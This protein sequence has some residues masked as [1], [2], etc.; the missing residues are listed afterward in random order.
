[1]DS[2]PLKELALECGAHVCGIAD[3]DL[4]QELPTIPENLLDGYTRAVSIGMAVPYGAFLT[5]DRAPTRLYMHHYRT[6][7]DILDRIALKI[8]AA[9]ESMGGKALAI[10]AS[11]ILDHKQLLGNIS[12]KAVA[13]VAG[14]GWQGKNLLLINPQ[15]GSRLRLVTVLTDLNLDPDAPVKNRCGKCSKCADAC[16][17][18]AIKN[19]TF[20]D[21]PRSRDEALYFERCVN[22]LT[23]DFAEELGLGKPV[24]GVCIK[25]CPWSRPRRK[26]SGGNGEFG[27]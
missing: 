1:M 13:R 22:K 20:A 26:S 9:V 18:G 3:L 2:K 25:V 10:P 24:C 21:H 11:E 16:P 17:A 5:I 15:Y 23:R 4:L 27:K 19:V 8:A 7:N 6:V 12:H 14:L